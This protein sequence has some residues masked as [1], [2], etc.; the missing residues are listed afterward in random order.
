V[1]VGIL[2]WMKTKSILSGGSSGPLFPYINQYLTEDQRTGVCSPVNLTSR[3]VLSS[4]FDRWLK[5]TGR[6]VRDLNEAVDLRFFAA[7][8]KGRYPKNA[9]PVNVASGCWRCSVGLELRPQLKQ[10]VQVHP[11]I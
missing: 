11:S 3:F 5:R 1:T 2:G 7:L 10:H 6:E 9:A 8:I 4:L